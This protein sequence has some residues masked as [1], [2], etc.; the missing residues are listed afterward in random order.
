[1]TENRSRRGGTKTP[2][3]RLR[4]HPAFGETAGG[5]RRAK[6][7]V[8]R[9]GYRQ[10]TRGAAPPRP[11][12]PPTATPSLTTSASLQLPSPTPPPPPRPPPAVW[13]TAGGGGGGKTP[14]GGAGDP[15]KKPGGPPPPPPPRANLRA[16]GK[17]GPVGPVRRCT[18]RVSRG[19]A[20]PAPTTAPAAPRTVG[21][22][23]T[24]RLPAAA[25]W[26]KHGFDAPSGARVLGHGTA[27]APD[28]AAVGGSHTHEPRVRVRNSAHF[29]VLAAPGGVLSAAKLRKRLWSIW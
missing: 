21:T 13:G 5:E 1:L 19:A 23:E 16:A 11:P 4:S 28:P 3:T 17:E 22:V 20:R 26:A 6:P 2:N 9:A 18:S 29:G 15:Q 24:G 27:T 8:V 12:P 10:R 25:N 14:G 7:R